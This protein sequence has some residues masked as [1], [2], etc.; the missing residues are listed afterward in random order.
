MV[1]NKTQTPGLSDREVANKHSATVRKV[2]T[3]P[4]TCKP[5]TLQG[6]LAILH[7]K[8]TMQVEFTETKTYNLNP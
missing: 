6:I 5:A 7:G 2:V 8:L 1:G 3:A 4:Q